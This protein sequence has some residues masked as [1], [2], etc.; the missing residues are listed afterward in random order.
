[1]ERLGLPDVARTLGEERSSRLAKAAMDQSSRKTWVSVLVAAVIVVFVLAVAAVGGAAY[2]IRSHV[3]TQVTP[4]SNAEEQFTQARA[5]FAGQQALIE[6]RMGDQPIVHRDLASG[7]GP[8]TPL[9]SMRVI[10]Y[11]RTSGKLVQIS[12]PFWLLRLAP[13]K[14]FSFLGDRGIDVDTDRVQLKLEDVERRGPGLILDT[15]DRK[16]SQVLVWTE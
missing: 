12:I 7:A 10:A 9:Q 13:S 1:V 3:N 14:N 5:R 4:G 15:T 16:G 8:G 6:V 11:D 2:F